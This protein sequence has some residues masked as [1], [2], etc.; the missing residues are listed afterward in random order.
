MSDQTPPPSE[1]PESVPTPEPV[2]Y[3]P[4]TADQPVAY[5]PAPPVTVPATGQQNG[6]GVAALVFGIVQFFCLP[7]IGAILAIVFGRIGI[8]KAKRGEASN[9]GMAKAGFWLG[10]VGLVLSIIGGIITVI[11]LIF[12]VNTVNTNTSADVNSQ[13]GL[14]D[15]QY[16]IQQVDANYALNDRCGFTGDAEN[17]S[18]AVVKIGVTV[19]GSGSTQCGSDAMDVDAV[20]FDVTNGVAE[21]LEVQ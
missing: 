18:G 6:M 1:Q 15:G 9:G 8:N 7:F 21:I 13:T 16:A 12:A 5:T 19:S 14:P 11:V 17:A 20:R 10:I 2:V 3:T 4:P